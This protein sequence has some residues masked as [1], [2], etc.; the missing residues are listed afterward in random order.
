M[1]ASEREEAGERGGE[2]RG[3]AILGEAA[4]D[5]D[6]DPLR[7]EISFIDL[8]YADSSTMMFSL[9][10]GYTIRA[11]NVQMSTAVRSATL[12]HAR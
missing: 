4:I 3:E 2:E 10:L 5:G 11:P 1:S 7:R 12:D 8:V 6:L 9:A